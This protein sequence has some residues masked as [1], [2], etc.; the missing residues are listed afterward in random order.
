MVDFLSGLNERL[1]GYAELVPAA[2]LVPSVEELAR[3]LRGIAR[4][5]A[6]LC[7][8]RRIGTSRGG[9]ALEVLSVGAGRRSVLVVGGPHPNEPVGYATVA[10]LADL[11]TAR[12]ELRD[13]VAW[14]FLPCV[15]PDGAALN[16][17]W[18]SMPLDLHTE[19]RYFYRPALAEQPEWTFPIPWR[20][21]LHRFGLPEQQ[22]LAELVDELEPA[23]I[24]SLHNAE[25]GETFFVVSRDVPGLAAHLAAVAARH[26]L[27]AGEAAPSDVVGWPVLGDGVYRMPPI[28]ELVIRDHGQQAPAYGAHLAHHAARHGTLTLLPEVPRWHVATRF[29]DSPAVALAVL[30]EALTGETAEVLRLLGQAGHPGDVFARAAAD[31]AAVA[32]AVTRS[33]Q[34][35]A[36]DDTPVPGTE[37][38]EAHYARVMLTLRSAGMALRSVCEEPPGKAVR[39][40]RARLERLLFERARQCERQL[41]ARPVGLRRLVAVQACAAV[42]AAV[43]AR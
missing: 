34:Q 14:N 2:E 4:R 8:M 12:P 38:A 24:V 40:T 7:R 23:A 10:F 9:R 25:F 41:R 30:A 3:R 27:P 21:Q 17:E 42:A 18:T 26:G 29:E 37:L 15:D 22:A 19:H 31:T 43:L 32:D 16:S 20:G 5:E 33:W 13:G 1:A 28:E 11:M 6:G 36:Q 35:R 39:S